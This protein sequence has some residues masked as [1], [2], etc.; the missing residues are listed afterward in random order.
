M[1]ELLLKFSQ[2]TGIYS[3]M[4]TPWGWPVM[5]SIHFIGLSLLVGTVGIFDLRM[6]GFARAIP[7]AALHRLVPLGVLGF[8]MNLCSGLMFVSSV[9]DQYLYNPA[10]RIKMLFVFLAGV[11]MLMFYRV[12]GARLAGTPSRRCVRFRSRS[13]R[14]VPAFGLTRGGRLI[15]VWRRRRW[16]NSRVG[17]QTRK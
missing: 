13:I 8:M 7:L 1:E 10:F 2:S 4:H 17:R 6:L 15:R 16:R 5:E 11:N 12:T 9:P 3:F 14:M